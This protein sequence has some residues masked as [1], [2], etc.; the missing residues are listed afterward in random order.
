MGRSC[1]HAEHDSS[2]E[3]QAYAIKSIRVACA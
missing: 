2:Q 3:L 1:P